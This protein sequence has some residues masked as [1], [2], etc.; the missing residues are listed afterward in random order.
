MHSGVVLLV[1]VSSKSGEQNKCQ[2]RIQVSRLR[3][4]DLNFGP[5]CELALGSG[6]EDHGVALVRPAHRTD[7]V[8]SK[9][10]NL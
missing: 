3:R 5:A 1:E 9:N 7:S 8:C 4:K 2:G 6:N 10:K